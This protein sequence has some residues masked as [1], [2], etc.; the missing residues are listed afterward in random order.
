MWGRLVIYGNRFNKVSL[1]GSH[2]DYLPKANMT[3]LM[4]HNYIYRHMAVDQVVLWDY[5]LYVFLHVKMR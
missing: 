1:W 5:G 4:S 2:H 3:K